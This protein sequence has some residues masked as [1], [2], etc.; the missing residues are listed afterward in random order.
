MNT[1]LLSYAPTEPEPVVQSP[2]AHLVIMET[3][4]RHCGFHMTK[5][6]AKEIVDTMPQDCFDHEVRMEVVQHRAWHKNTGC[7]VEDC[8]SGRLYHG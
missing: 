3:K 5:T 4:G 2:L 6:W 7:L 8:L 1:P